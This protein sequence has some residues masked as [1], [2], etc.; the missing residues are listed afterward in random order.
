MKSSISQLLSQWMFAKHDWTSV[1][2][3]P[4]FWQHFVPTELFFQF[5]ANKCFFLRS[6]QRFFF[7]L[8]CPE[9]CLGTTTKLVSLVSCLQI[10]VQ[11]W[12]SQNFLRSSYDHFQT[13]RSKNQKKLNKSGSCKGT[14]IQIMNVSCSLVIF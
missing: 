13:A 3:I 1:C 7:L 11:G 12:Y 8:R 4:S 10:K 6:R 2:F 9:N 5:F 14:P